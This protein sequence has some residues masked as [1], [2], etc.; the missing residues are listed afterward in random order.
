MDVIEIEALV[1]LIVSGLTIMLVKLSDPKNAL[2][3]DMR[4]SFI[5]ITLELSASL[6]VICFAINLKFLFSRWVQI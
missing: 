4:N 2:P 3:N 5:V 6:V 1:L